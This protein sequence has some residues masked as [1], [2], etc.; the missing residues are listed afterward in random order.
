MRRC[1]VYWP[2]R[3]LQQAPQ[4][5]QA[6]HLANVSQLRTNIFCQCLPSSGCPGRW[7]V[8]KTEGIVPPDRFGFGHQ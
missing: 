7:L 8:G 4:V 6:G 1:E 5:A 3:L 2:W